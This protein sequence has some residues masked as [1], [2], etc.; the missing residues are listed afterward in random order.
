[1][2][3]QPKI[4]YL[5][6]YTV[7]DFLID[8]IFLHVDLH[9]TE[10]QVKT[11]L[12]LRRNPQSQHLKT[13]LMLNG[14]AIKLQA[15]LLNG[16]PLRENEFKVDDEHLTIPNV[17]DDFILETEVVIQPQLNTQLSGL[18]KAQ[19]VFCT[20]CEAH[21][22]RR[23]TYFLDRPDILTRFTVAITADPQKYPVLLSNGNLI[24]KKQ[25][26]DGR[27][28][29]KWEDPTLKPCYLFALV[30][31]DLDCL[32]DH[33][34]TRSGRKITLRIYVEKGK[35]DE[36]DFAM[37]SLK[38]AM[39]WDEEVYG[40]EYDLDIYMIVAVS[41]FN[42]GAMENKGLNIFNS[43]YILAKPETATDDDYGHIE[44][45]IGH[46]YFHNW[47]GN[48]ITCRDWFQ[49]TLKEGLTIF[50]DQQFSADMFS[51][52]IQR[53]E[54]ANVIRTAQFA[55]DASPMAH[56]IRPESYIEVNNFYT[57][58]VY[59]KGSEVI[60]M[61]RTLIGA[62]N[63]A[64][65]MT[66]YFTRHDGQAVTTE[67][68]IKAMEDASGMDLT[69]FRRWYS[70]A[71]TPVLTITGEYDEKN[72]IFTLKVEQSCPPT[73]GQPRKE[74]FHI[75]LM[76]GLLDAKGRDLPL[77]L[78]GETKKQ[79]GRTRVLSLRDKTSVFRFVGI[80]EKPIPSLLR[81]FSA[82]VKV[83]YDYS[84]E[85]LLFLLAH[86]SDDFNRWDA[87]Q[88][89]AT[90]ILLHLIADYQQE[91]P[92]TLPPTVVAAFKQLLSDKK[93]DQALVVQML[94]LP[95]ESYLLECQMTVDVDA[96]HQVR[97]F[98]KTELAKHLHEAFEKVYRANHSRKPYRFTAKAI[99]QRAL[100]NICLAYWVRQGDEGVRQQC[101]QQFSQA[102]NM[103]D[104]MGAL[105]ALNS[106]DCSERQHA[107]TAFYDK[108]QRDDLVVDKWFA[109]QALSPLPDTFSKV[110]T[111][112]K[113]P[114]FNLRRPNRVRAL[115]GAFSQNH[116]HF[117]RPDGA[118]YALLADYIIQL[119]VINSHVAARLVEPLLRWQKFDV[120]RQA[121]MKKQLQIIL[122]TPH[123]SK[124]VYE[125]VSRGLGL[126]Y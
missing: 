21:G 78:E 95:P 16:K 126:K 9:E 100:K 53:I 89:L 5:K 24:D 10:T 102:D 59:N 91:K 44:S 112:L 38:E 39:R 74:N 1:M 2:T 98:V 109:L 106:L 6:D 76:I 87:G 119:N 103:T 11:V 107:L 54:D 96:T 47:S 18:Y 88:R 121:L 52:V 60:R 22:F 70:Q 114:A 27:A 36:V 104:V 72:H 55:Q 61:I 15:I 71:G 41:D 93:L 14:E 23:I 64:K 32:E 26:P 43:K 83:N 79:A 86:D 30:A 111:L 28:W 113:H 37:E 40:R 125:L 94:T 42:A 62:E 85:E 46:E 118:G 69:Q 49:I 80:P 110:Q 116:V 84:D 31:G 81:D 7:P 97:E 51:P 8:H 90:N 34:K 122:K 19:N 20:Q 57:V 65:G 99:K 105:Y 33:F 124:D 50:R 12:M 115:L 45:V 17:P 117:H 120:H 63:F 35:L 68:F 101:F 3:Q 77:Q 67:E 75:P 123:L 4:T 92:L 25:L 13:P 58:T 56:P 66:L 29:V 73:P 48:R 82:P 108:W